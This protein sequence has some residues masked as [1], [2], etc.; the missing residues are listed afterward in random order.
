M[1]D[2]VFTAQEELMKTLHDAVVTMD[3]DLVKTLCS[4]AI[5][6][7]FNARAILKSGMMTAMEKVG[8]L[9]ASGEY[10]V[11]ELLLCADA[12]RAGVAILGPYLGED[13]T[14]QKKKLLLGTVEGD[15]HDV[16]KNIVKIMFETTGWEVHDLGKDVPARVFVEEQGKLGADMVALSALM[17]TTMFA[18]P[19]TIKAL[20]EAYPKTPVI[21]GGAP[22]SREIAASFGADGYAADAGEAV[23]EA[24]SV[25]GRFGL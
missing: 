23:A 14:E 15:I 10:Y 12:L 6:Q 4:S 21:V 1:T 22:L 7:G 5:A 18:I 11:S 3:E 19:K 25:L 9:Y 13:G 8:E 20:K 16:G 2:T 17:S 24:R